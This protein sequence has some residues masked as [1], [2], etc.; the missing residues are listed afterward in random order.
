MVKDRLPVGRTAVTAKPPSDAGADGQFRANIAAR[1]RIPTSPC[2]PLTAGTGSAGAVGDGPLVTCTATASVSYRSHL[3]LRAGRVA[4]RVAQRLLDDAI[5]REPDTSRYGPRLP[6]DPRGDGPSAGS[7]VRRPPRAGRARVAAPCRGRRPTVVAEDAQHPAGLGQRL[8]RGRPD[9]GEALRRSGGASA[10]RYGAASA[11]IAIT[12]MWWATTSWSSRAI[13]ARSS[14]SARRCRSDS[15]IEVCSASRRRV[16]TSARG[17]CGGDEHRAGQAGDLQQV[18]RPDPAGGGGRQDG[19]GGDGQEPEL[20]Q[21]PG[22]DPPKDDGERGQIDQQGGIR[23]QGGRAGRAGGQRGG[24]RDRERQ[25]PGEQRG[26]ERQQ[27]WKRLRHPQ[28]RGHPV[29]HAVVGERR[30][31]AGPTEHARGPH[32]QHRWQPRGRP[33]GRRVPQ[34][35]DK[36]ARRR[37]EIGADRPQP[38][39]HGDVSSAQAS[40]ARSTRL[41]TATARMA[42]PHNRT[43]DAQPPRLPATSGDT[44]EDCASFCSTDSGLA[45]TTTMPVAEQ[46]AH[47]SRCQQD[48]DHRDRPGRRGPQDGAQG[49]ADQPDRRDAQRHPDQRRH[50]VAGGV[51]RIGQE[52]GADPD[53]HHAAEQ[54]GGERPRGDHDR[55]GEQDHYPARRS[56]QGDA[57]RAAA[58]LPSHH[59]HAGEGPGDLGEHRPGEAAA[60]DGVVRLQAPGQAHEDGYRWHD[61]HRGHPDPEDRRQRP[62]LRP[63]GRQ[64][65]H[66]TSPGTRRVTSA[67]MSVPYSTLE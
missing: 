19:A 45:P 5:R 56:G 34:R 67:G 54:S 38:T 27:Q 32:H 3:D 65:L 18:R 35:R 29:G 53:R 40:R 64:R 33:A 66:E 31:P 24:D 58:V 9:R 13:R 43:N 41:A 63:L 49:E 21:D 61:G 47:Q 48:T 57:D 30:I 51:A 1:S 22:P 12:D 20:D 39:G 28:R 26:E 8:Q 17:E 16:S 37:Q 60:E 46:R 7:P 25:P 11:W 36:T 42:A 2:P 6:G 59:E 14:S 44:S 15:L 50:R 10:T 23:P 55:L 62:H 52:R 4:H